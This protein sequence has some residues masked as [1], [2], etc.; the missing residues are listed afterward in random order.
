M[1]VVLFVYNGKKETQELQPVVMLAH[2]VYLLVETWKDGYPDGML[3][4]CSTMRELTKEIVGNG[5]HTI[6]TPG[7]EPGYTENSVFLLVHENCYLAPLFKSNGVDFT[8]ASGK[9]ILSFE[10]EYQIWVSQVL[11]GA[12]F[13]RERK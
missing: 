10:K 9:L 13:L 12:R 1:K 8:T 4:E 3:C 5:Y 11:R 7:W 2:N 6:R